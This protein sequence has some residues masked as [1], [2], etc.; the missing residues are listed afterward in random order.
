MCDP[1]AG[2]I[3]GVEALVGS[4]GGGEG[5]VLQDAKVPCEQQK[6]QRGRA[7]FALIAVK[8]ED[9]AV[10]D[11]GCREGQELS[12]GIRLKERERGIDEVEPEVVG[13]GAGQVMGVVRGQAAGVAESALV[14]GRLAGV[15]DWMTGCSGPTGGEA[16]D[17]DA[18]MDFARC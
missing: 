2:P 15:D 17:K 8:C 3:G 18:G 7:G 13:V 4:A 6:R 1:G 11:A 10:V 5:T 16:A 9:C 14:A 12:E